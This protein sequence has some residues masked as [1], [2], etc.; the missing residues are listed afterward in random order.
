MKKIEFGSGKGN[1]FYHCQK[2]E[3]LYNVDMEFV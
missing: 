2:V 3:T 1:E